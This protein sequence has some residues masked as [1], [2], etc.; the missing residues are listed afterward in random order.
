MAKRNAIIK[1]LPVVETLG[2]V[3]VICCDKTGTLTKNEMTVTQIL[4]ADHHHA[5]LTGVGYKGEGQIKIVHS[6]EKSS[7]DTAIKSVQ[8]VLEVGT[9]CNN[10]SITS[11]G[12]HGNPTEGAL[13][14]AAAKAGLHDMRRLYRRLEEW[15]FSSDTKIM[16]VKC[17][18]EL[19]KN[20]TV[21]FV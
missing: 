8:K 3:D 2:C 12:L 4:T 15:P 11:D 20:Y 1:K 6:P 18:P 19:S 7:H 17:E 21:V 9:V 13:L 14:A 10:A 5:E 16:A